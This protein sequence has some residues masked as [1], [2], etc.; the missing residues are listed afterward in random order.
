ML[1]VAI[2]SL[3]YL[4]FGT[5]ASAVVIALLFVPAVRDAYR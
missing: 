2:G 5:I 3:W 4:V 1:V